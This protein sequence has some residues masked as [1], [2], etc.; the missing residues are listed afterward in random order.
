LTYHE[1]FHTAVMRW[2][3]GEIDIA[4]R[5]SEI[6]AAPGALPE[7]AP[8]SAQQDLE[9]RDFTINAI[10]VA[11]AGEQAGRLRSV[12]GALDDLTARRLRILH[13]ASFSDDP[14]RIPR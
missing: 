7:V 1:R 5:R 3:E 6:Y 10:A 9:R 12:E 2:S 11:L 8:G 4:M 13:D 14:T